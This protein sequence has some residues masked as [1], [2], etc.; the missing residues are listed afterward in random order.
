[1][2]SARLLQPASSY[3]DLLPTSTTFRRPYIRPTQPTNHHTMSNKPIPGPPPAYTEQAEPAASHPHLQQPLPMPQPNIHSSPSQQ[4]PE[5]P[6]YPHSPAPYS[7]HHHH[8]HHHPHPHQQYQHQHGYGP[9]PLVQQEAVLLPYFD[10]RS[11]FSIQ[12]AATRA[13]WRFFLA[14][15]YAWAV[16][17]VVGVVTGAEIQVATRRY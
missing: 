4:Y 14:L 17:F 9:T 11:A 3:H 10:P 12:E 15:V 2:N 1:M 7:H 5:S 6:Y 13:K 16:L 8:P